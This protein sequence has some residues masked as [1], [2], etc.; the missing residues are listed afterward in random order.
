[1]KKKTIDNKKDTSKDTSKEKE[2]RF[3]QALNLPTICNINPRSIYN[4]ADEFHTL[5]EE[6]ELDLIFISESWEREYLPLDQIIKLEDHTVI[7]NVSQRV[8]IGGRPAIIANKNKFNVQNVTN[9]LV[10]IP[11]GVE[12]VWCVLTPK[13]VKHNSKIQK[14]ACCSIYS[15]PASN[16]KTLLLDHISDAY[17]TLCTKYGRGL[18]FCLAGDTNDLKLDSILSLSPSLVQ[19]VKTWT[20]LDPPAIL[21]PVIMTLSNLYQEPVCLEPLDADQDKH[22]KKSD[23]R[24]VIA[25]PINMFD[26]KC[27][28]QTREV[29]I[30]PFP[31]SG[32]L[33][34]KNWL[35]DYQ[36]D[37][38]YSAESAHDKAKIFQNIL[39]EKLD[40]IFPEKT[41]KINSD[42]QPWVSFKL[43]QLDRRRKRLYRKERKSENWRRL[44]KMFRKE[45][46][47]AKADFYKKSVA[48]LKLSKPG[49]WYKCLKRITSHDQQKN[50]Q[51]NVDQINHLSDQ[52]QAEKIA[53]KF[54]SIQN[55][56]DAL[57]T[58]DISVPPFNESEIP[59]FHPAQIW[60]ALSRLDINKATVPG[61]FPAKLIKYF[62]AYL[63]DPFTDILNTSIKRGEYPEIYKFE[64]STPV[65]KSYP[66]LDVSQLRN[67]SGLLT[68]D[69]VAE[70]LIA[71]LIISDMEAKFDPSQ[72]GNQRGVS[73]QHYLIQMLHRILTALDNNS[74]GDI[75]AVV[76]NLIDWNNAFPRQCPKL[77]IESF[78][79]NGVRPSLIP[80][81]IN[82][83]QDRKM[84]VKWHGCRSVPK[85]IKGGGPQG[86]TL[87][88]LEYLS[89]SNNNADC[90][91]VRDRFK[92]I[93]DLSVLEIVN[94]LTV[95]ITSFNLKQQ[96]P[97]DIPTHNQF[98][99]PDNL[100]SQDWLDK[101]N[102]WTEDQL[103][104]INEKKTKTMIFNFT[105]NYKF[106]TRLKLKGEN[107]EVINSTRLLGTMLTDDLKWDLNISTI[108]KKANA[109]MEL[110]RRVA[111][112]GTP[113]E[114]LKIIYIL[115]IRSLLEQSATVWH[116]SLTEENI[117]DLERVQKT[118]I[119]VILQDKYKGY[120]NGLAQLD[121]E[122][123][124]DRR[125]E[126][127]LNFAKKCTKS[128]KLKHMFPLN[129]KSHTMETRKDEK[130]KVQFANTERLKNSAVIYMQNLLNENELKEN[131]SQV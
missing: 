18:H 73:I 70:K 66:T 109:R 85:D 64:I 93:D 78:I 34:M 16:K 13:N 4:K 54:A 22:G 27:S 58:E 26:N 102:K 24:I 117:N 101:I 30:R 104:I 123:L 29:K 87:G 37:E 1:M 115:F 91:D 59:Q 114:D 103:M 32:I 130:Y 128:D 38:V 68:F 5:V 21:D 43:K 28:R 31:Q 60:F 124:E 19:I 48:D 72:F 71:E 9:T 110:L 51:P 44:E 50:E 92:F 36:W 40:E 20:R 77:G 129:V 116:S 3:E 125:E 121:I 69:K 56:Y 2:N 122:T 53:E 33:K 15:K 61:D 65:P 89:Q 47:S 100:A 41:R 105:E 6:E 131:A 111:S 23:H 81:L 126:L 7:S 88:L 112:F 108:V 84:S 14:I 11:W 97:A 12:A 83:F 63:T 86:A 46:K 79:Q 52:Q 120:K 90:V 74:R 67:I 96:I 95:G 113:A 80:V 10:Q 76:A 94:L 75:F 39:L 35:I 106:T 45:M 42:D 107:V 98:I 25:K 119:K 127:C 62:A 55:E 17:N 118:A 49:Q 8:G 82:Y 99:P 57:K